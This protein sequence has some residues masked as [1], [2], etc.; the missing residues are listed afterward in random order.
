MMD[1]GGDQEKMPETFI[2][3]NKHTKRAAFTLIELLVVIAIIALLLAIIMPS[4]NR[5]RELARRLMCQSNVRQLT[6]A[7]IVYAGD[8]DSKLPYKPEGSMTFPHIWWEANSGAPDN[9]IFFDGYLDG[10]ILEQ[11]GVWTEGVDEAPK[12]MYCPSVK[13]ANTKYF[14]YGRQWPTKQSSGWRPFE[15]SY[16]YFNLGEL[17]DNVG[18]WFSVAPMPL[19]TNDRGALPVF[20]DLIEIYGSITII[21]AP[22]QD[23]RQVN[24]FKWG[25]GE[26]IPSEDYL[27]LGMNMGHLD[28][29]GSW[30]DYDDCEVY[31]IFGGI[32]NV[33]GKPL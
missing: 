32:L 33:W 5:A 7:F 6:I 29:S 19:T 23:F 17:K 27:P 22:G 26:F 24:H 21:T 2:A 25:F 20:G 9:R 3:L 14:G 16:G 15:S 4:L 12:S 11:Q 8:Y 18:Q 10:F 13:G 28:G 1:K 30:Y 31:S